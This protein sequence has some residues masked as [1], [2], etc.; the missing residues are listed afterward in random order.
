MG[1][2]E[3]EADAAAVCLIIHTLVGGA[4]VQMFGLTRSAAPSS[5]HCGRREGSCGAAEEETGG[6]ITMQHEPFDSVWSRIIAHAK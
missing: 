2:A 4:E 5:S 6:V 1:R 3:L